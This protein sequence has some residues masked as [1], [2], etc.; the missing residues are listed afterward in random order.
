MTKFKNKNSIALR[1]LKR[2]KKEEFE[3]I[4]INLNLKQN[5]FLFTDQE[6][7]DPKLKLL[8][9]FKTPLKPK[10]WYRDIKVYSLSMR[11]SFFQILL[12]K[13]YKYR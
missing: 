10:E 11:L 9:I 5:E 7:K 13:N 2:I 12:L 1:F 6:I 3:R 8:K 4:F